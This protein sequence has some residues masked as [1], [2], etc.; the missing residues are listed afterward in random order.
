MSPR[1]S[2]PRLFVDRTCGE[3][4][5]AA[6][7][8]LELPSVA[9]RHV[10]VLRLQPG[11]EL[12]LFDGRGG[13]WAA[14]VVRMGRSD[15][16]VRLLNHEAVERE[17]PLAVTLAVCMPANDRM[18]DLVE[19]ATE[20]GAAAIVPLVSE[21]SVLRL[22]GDRAAKRQVHWQAVAVAASEQSGRNRV[23]VV[24]PVQ[25]LDAFLGQA[26]GEGECE[27]IVRCQLSLAPTATALGQALEH[28]SDGASMKANAHITLLSGPEGGLSAGEQDRAQQAGF[29]PVS[30]GP[31]TLRADT[32]P[33][34]ALAAIG[35]FALAG[36]PDR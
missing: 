17:L 24:H 20:L 4:T 12:T 33:L 21:R 7:L 22:S 18:D 30:L 1:P 25:G 2:S 5:W 29:R 26:N 8:E 11:S 3:P 19:K 23:P 28:S 14:T 31:R 35:V 9:A 34:A 27:V 6:G 10:Q 32:A 15:V 36:G 16:A 13:Q